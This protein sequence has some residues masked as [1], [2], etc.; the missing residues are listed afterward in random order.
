V[1]NGAS[2]GDEINYRGCRPG[3]PPTNTDHLRV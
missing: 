2:E 3:S 1:R